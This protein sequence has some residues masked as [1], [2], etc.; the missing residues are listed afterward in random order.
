MAIPITFSGD[1]SGAFRTVLDLEISNREAEKFDAF[2]LQR[3]NASKTLAWATN[4]RMQNELV[5]LR[6]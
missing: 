1:C 5:G 6:L 4:Q 3:V 2:A